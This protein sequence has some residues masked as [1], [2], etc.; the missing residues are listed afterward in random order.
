MRIQESFVATMYFGTSL[1]C[2]GLVLFG[3]AVKL[4]FADVL[5]ILWSAVCAVLD[6]CRGGPLHTAYEHYIRMY[7]MEK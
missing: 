4:F 2:F 6:C 1:W 5:M 7:Y 3:F